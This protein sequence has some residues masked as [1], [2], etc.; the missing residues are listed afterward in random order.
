MIDLRRALDYLLGRGRCE[1]GEVGYVGLSFGGIL[2]ALLAG[3]DD[4][5]GAAV[6][7][8]AGGD[9]RALVSESELQVLLPEGIDESSPERFEQALDLLDPVDPVDPVHW[10]GHASGPVLM[11]NGTDDQIVPGAS[12]TALHEAAQEPKE[13]LW[14]EGP[15]NPFVGPPREQVGDALGSFLDDWPAGL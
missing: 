15:H 5:V 2:G 11:I 1:G 10:I 13:V 8:V 9:W 14:Y 4:R 7:V 12:A 6:L 3:V